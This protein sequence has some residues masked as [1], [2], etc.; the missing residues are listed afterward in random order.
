MSSI[1]EVLLPGVS[2]KFQVET[3]TGD[4]LVIS[5]SNKI[6]SPTDFSAMK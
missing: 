1:S 4:R 5:Q 6:L 3:M 2:S